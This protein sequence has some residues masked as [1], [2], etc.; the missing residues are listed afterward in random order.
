MT[1]AGWVSIS[2]AARIYDKYRKWVCNQIKQYEITTKKSDTDNKVML[3]L[4]DLI[5]HRGEPLAK[6]TP[7]TV[8]NHTQEPQLITPQFTPIEIALLEQENKFL[9]DRIVEL[10]ANRRIKREIT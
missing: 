9:R 7:T 6:D 2:E 1:D 5:A 3:Q 10:E 4:A 8:E